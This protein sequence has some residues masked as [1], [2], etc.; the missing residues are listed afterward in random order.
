MFTKTAAFYDAI[1]QWKNYALEN[2]HRAIAKMT[3]HLQIG[4][5]LHDPEGLM[6]RGFYLGLRSR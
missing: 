2:L 4:G 3:R 5:V 1:Y 6:G